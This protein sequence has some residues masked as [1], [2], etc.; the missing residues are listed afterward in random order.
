LESVLVHELTHA[1]QFKTTAE[2][3]MF[4]RKLFNGTLQDIIL[5]ALNET[6]N[7]SQIRP[8]IGRKIKLW[9][10]TKDTSDSKLIL[11]IISETI[12]NRPL[13]RA[14]WSEIVQSL[15]QGYQQMEESKS[16]ID[17][18]L[19]EFENIVMSQYKDIAIAINRG[20]GAQK[21]VDKLIE[22]YDFPP[23]ATKSLYKMFYKL[24]ASGPAS[25]LVS[26]ELG[27][28][29]PYRGNTKWCGK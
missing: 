23:F 17:A 7:I 28:K 25:E 21:I 5:G 26:Q 12:P 19:G 1:A 6:K 2:D 11:Q 3:P 9:L 29:N 8:N 14:E 15:S 20:W 18:S 10:G 27:G 22:F 24:M 16:E 13:S 4:K